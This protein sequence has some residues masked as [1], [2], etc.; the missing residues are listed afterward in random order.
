MTIL[1][2][3]QIRAELRTLREQRPA[4]YGLLDSYLSDVRDGI[5]TCRR[6]YPSTTQIAAE[7]DDPGITTQMLGN[8]LSLLARIGVIGIYSDRNNGNRYDLTE[9]DPTR[10]QHLS[11]LLT[12]DSA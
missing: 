8:V 9:Y 12:T 10:M 1:M 3:A 2:E 6:N 4:Q 5:E 11:R 7:L